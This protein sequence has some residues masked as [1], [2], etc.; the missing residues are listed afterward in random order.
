MSVPRLSDLFRLT[1]IAYLEGLAGKRKNYSWPESTLYSPYICDNIRSVAHRVIHPESSHDEMSATYKLAR[2]AA[3]IVT[4]IIKGNHSVFEFLRIN[5][6]D[7]KTGKRHNILSQ[8]RQV[9]EYRC[10][11]LD[12]LIDV[13]EAYELSSQFTGEYNVDDF[14]FVAIRDSISA[15]L[16]GECATVSVSKDSSGSSN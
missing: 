12:V 11:M 4:R 16:N 2:Q 6:L 7:I 14:N 10:A 5:D 1:H 3:L 13:I 9:R 15:K 8:P